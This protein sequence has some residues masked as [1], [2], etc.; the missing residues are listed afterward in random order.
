[1]LYY[2]GDPKRNKLTKEQDSYYIEISQWIY[3]EN[4]M[5]GFLI[6]AL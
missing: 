6:M 5:N 4:Q 2:Q 3:G 1:M